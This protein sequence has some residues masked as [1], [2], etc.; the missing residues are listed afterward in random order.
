MEPHGLLKVGIATLVVGL[1]LGI[2]VP[3]TQFGGVFPAPWVLGVSVLPLAWGAIW[4]YLAR[5]RTWWLWL[6]LQW[7]SLSL[8]LMWFV[9][10]EMG[11]TSQ[12]ATG[13]VVLGLLI[14]V[15]WMAPVAVISVF[16][17]RR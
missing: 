9:G 7:M 11:W 2:I 14:L 3:F 17:L 5:R 4:A 6:L 12:A 10:R 1:V 15:V 8:A 13:G 16:P